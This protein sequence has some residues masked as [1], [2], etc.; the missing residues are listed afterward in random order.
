MGGALTKAHG[1]SLNG[2]VCCGSE[3]QFRVR[4]VIPNLILRERNKVQYKTIKPSIKTNKTK[5]TFS[6]S[7]NPNPGEAPYS[8]GAKNGSDMDGHLWKPYPHP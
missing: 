5:P 6:P 8:G 1:W 4:L 7:P 2:F 3:I